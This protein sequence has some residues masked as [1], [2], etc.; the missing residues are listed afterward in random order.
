M[1]KEYGK[2]P[3]NLTLKRAR[4]YQVRDLSTIRN[5]LEKKLYLVSEEPR[6]IKSEE[7]PTIVQEEMF[8]D[9]SYYNT[10][11]RSVA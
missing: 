1:A 4:Y 6:L 2:E 8:R 7:K 5:I 10:T 11:E 9:L 3:V